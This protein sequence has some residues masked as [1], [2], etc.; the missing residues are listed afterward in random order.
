MPFS[1]NMPGRKSKTKEIGPDAKKVYGRRAGMTS[2]GKSKE[3]IMQQQALD[4]ERGKGGP[5]MPTSPDK[6]E[7]FE[8]ETTVRFDNAQEVDHAFRKGDL[9]WDRYMEVNG[10][11][12]TFRTSSSANLTDMLLGKKKAYA[13]YTVPTPHVKAAKEK[14]MGQWMVLMFKPEGTSKLVPAGLT[15][16]SGS[17]G[18][19]MYE[20]EEITEQNQHVIGDVVLLKISLPSGVVSLKGK[21][22]T[23]AEISSL[24]VDSKPQVIG[25]T[26]RFRNHNASGNTITAPLCCQQ[27][28][29][30]ADGGVEYRPVVELDIEVDGKPLSKAQFNLNDRSAMEHQVLIGQNILEKAGFIVDPSQ[31]TMEQPPQPARSE[32]MGEEEI[33]DLDELSDEQVELLMEEIALYLEEE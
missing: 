33:T 29:K 16:T 22:D 23:G 15:F 6:E 8:P 7:Q 1:F 24:H 17:R 28:V 31:N 21:V 2:R 13:V 5:K 12:Y 18:R 26:V 25:E 3:E 9:K 11:K 32:P 14:D 10:F 30:S 4:F 20:N 19:A 27:A